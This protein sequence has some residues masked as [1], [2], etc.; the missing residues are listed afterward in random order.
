MKQSLIFLPL[1][2]GCVSAT[3]PKADLAL[4]KTEY[5]TDGEIFNPCNGEYVSV[6]KHVVNTI[7]SGTVKYKITFDGTGD[8]TGLPYS[9]SISDQYSL[10]HQ[11]EV[12]ELL[13]NSPGLSW[14]LEVAWSGDKV[15]TNTSVCQ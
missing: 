12:V 15:I 4:S 2:L 11:R 6:T 13:T 3:E 9:G 7:A 1:V 10:N 5:T 14:K 8:Q